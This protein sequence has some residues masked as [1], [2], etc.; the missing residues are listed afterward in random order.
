LIAAVFSTFSLG[1]NGAVADAQEKAATGPLRFQEIVTVQGGTRN[2]IYS[3]ARAWLSE[4]FMGPKDSVVQDI[5][6]GIL[7]ATSAQ[8]YVPPFMGTSCSGWLHY[9][10]QLVARDGRCLVTIDGFR[11]EGDPFCNKRSFGLLTGDWL[12]AR[13]TR[14]IFDM[15]LQPPR[16]EADDMET[17]L[18]MKE[19]A[20]TLA[21]ALARSLRAK[22]ATTRRS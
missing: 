1:L 22:L 15:T 10:V 17:W 19:R 8:R 5:R 21:E 3:T 9:R 14:S 11:H 16:R 6:T 12:G 18:D 4:T 2:R 20:T 13:I 7:A